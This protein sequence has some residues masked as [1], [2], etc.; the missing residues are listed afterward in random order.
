MLNLKNYKN[1][2]FGKCFFFFAHNKYNGINYYY[3]QL[4]GG[5]L[6]KDIRRMFFGGNTAN[7]FYSFHDNIVDDDRTMLY[8]LKGMPGGGKSSLMKRIGKYMKEEGFTIEFHHCPSDPESLDSILIKE[9]RI[10]I[11]DGTAP[12]TMDPVYPGLKDKII[13]L[14]QFIDSQKLAKNK[15]K[16]IEAKLNNKRAYSRTFSYLNS[17]KSIYEL[18]V[19]NNK[20]GVDFEEVNNE[21][22][23][24]VDKIFSQKDIN[25]Q[26]IMFKERHSFSTANTPKGFVDYTDT[27]LEGVENIYFIDGE[28][29]TGKS[30]L[31]N[32]VIEECRIK[33]YSMEYYHDSTIPEKVE[34]L[35]IKELN[36][37]ITSN[38]TAM[39][40]SHRRINLNKYFKETV[41]I[42]D[43]Y[44]TYE[45]LK[46]KAISNLSEAKENHKIL[47]EMYRPNIDYSSIDKVRDK[48]LDEILTYAK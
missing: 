22:R 30:T 42:K 41:K 26:E 12:H 2:S 46:K 10:A 39:E 1:T 32:K 24:V 9:L 33:G 43:D 40:F 4:K 21:T 14:G 34:S 35:I 25:K 31:I 44:E 38:K 3:N 37:C 23:S 17:A 27:I 20:S 29:G 18:I 5:F 48:L 13:D 15:D 28:I 8:I 36:T 47:E 16:I 6:V 7:G 19:E 45:L 11:V